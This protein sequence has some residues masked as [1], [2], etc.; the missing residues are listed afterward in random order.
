MNRPNFSR[1]NNLCRLAGLAAAAGVGASFSSATVSAQSMSKGEA[2]TLIAYFSRTGHTRQ[3]ALAIKS[4]VEAD[5]FEIEP[6]TPYPAAYQDTVDLNSRQRAA[7]QCPGVERPIPNLSRYDTVFL[8][9]PVWA[10]DLPRL[11]YPFMSEQD[12]VGKTIAPFCTSAMSGLA[13]TVQTLRTLCPQS[14][15]RPGVS[16]AGGARG[17]NALVTTMA[18]DAR[19]RVQQWARQRF[20][21]R[22]LDATHARAND[23]EPTNP[24][25]QP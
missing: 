8:G 20:Q 17:H 23:N 24:T 3:A 19:R 12:F 15:V 2:R 6:A 9:Y 25:D 11:L 7:G 18:V 16:L 4:V 10:V 22:V 13:G 21:L 1:R 5:L 14:H